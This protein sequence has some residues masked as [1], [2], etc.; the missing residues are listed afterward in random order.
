M[1]TWFK[2]TLCFINALAMLVF[3]Y[4]WMNSNYTYGDERAIIQWSS[5]IKRVFL[6]LDE[7]PP[8]EDYLFINLSYEKELIQRE[9]GPG[10]ESI[11][12]RAQLARF[13]D[14][15]KRHPKA[16]RFTLCDVFFIVL[17]PHDSVL[18]ESVKGLNNIVFPT[19]ADPE[20]HIEPL[21]VNVP[22]ALAD[23]RMT[24]AGFLKFRLLQNDS[25]PSLP[26]FMYENIE[27][28]QMNSSS[29]L[30][31]DGNAPAFPSVIIDYQVRDHELLEQKEYPLVNLSELLLLP[32]EVIV[33]EFLKGRIILMGDFVTDKHMTIYGL[34]PGTVILLNTYLTLQSGYHKISLWWVLFILSAFAVFSYFMIFSEDS[35]DDGKIKS[36]VK[37]ALFLALISIVSYI[38]FQKHIQVLILTVYINVLLVAVRYK[39]GDLGLKQLKHWL[40][41]IRNTY[42]KLK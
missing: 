33:N 20:G 41:N 10:N 2:W 30:Y 4:V 12:D 24:K 22:H 15:I 11:T 40:A 26:V 28:K 38:L 25:L 29:G 9:D 8:R 32:E 13:F 35:E 23:Y 5:A 27:R 7:D 34:T 42:L 3:T 37:S 39:R 1:K 36:L 19:H 21:A 6:G 16:V 17:S 14:I 18:Q 31:W